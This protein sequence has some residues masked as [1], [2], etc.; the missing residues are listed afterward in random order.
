MPIKKLINL[1]ETQKAYFA[2]FLDS[3]GSIY[4]RIVRRKDYHIGFQ[5]TLSVSFFQKLKRK[6][7]FLQFKQE[8]G[9]GVFIKRNDQMCEFIL[10]GHAIVQPF[11]QEIIPFL[12]VKK[13]QAC[14]VLK[15]CELLPTHKKDPNR[16]LELCNLADQIAELNDSKNREMTAQVVRDHY[17]LMDEKKDVPVET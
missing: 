11:L 2:G 6:H 10:N 17:K 12:R 15:I 14:L 1:T 5:L 9:C 8:I 16:F 4:S 3:D 7:I 13:K